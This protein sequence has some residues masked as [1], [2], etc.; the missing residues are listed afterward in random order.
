VDGER[1]APL[2]FRGRLWD[3]NN[4]GRY[5]EA[6]G[7]YE[8]FETH[9]G[10]E[11][12]IRNPR[13][14]DR[15]L[16]GQVTAYQLARERPTY[17]D[18]RTGLRFDLTQEQRDDIHYGVWT[19]GMLDSFLPGPPGE[20]VQPGASK[21]IQFGTMA[22]FGIV[23]T[24]RLRPTGW[25]IELR[26]SVTVTSSHANPVFGGVWLEWLWYRMVG[27]RW[28]LAWRSQAGAQSSSDPEFHYFMGGLD[29]IR[30][31]ADNFIETRYF[32][33]ANLEVRFIAFDSTWFAVQP[34]VFVDGALARGLNDHT[35]GALSAGVGVRFMIP[36]FVHSG[37]R[38]DAAFAL[39]PLEPV[40][41]NVLSVGVYQFF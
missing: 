22:R 7:F 24:V 31:Y 10:G 14:F 5:L 18:V 11:V 27:E 19:E 1:A 40:G 15:R 30:G 23:N 2:R 41:L 26:P 35:I 4:L 37:L 12:W 39:A 13:L 8:R 33:L 16:D 28:T 32:G 20:N 38:V 9:N 21:G 25:S 17:A 29:L 36:R 34:A 3:I 6:G